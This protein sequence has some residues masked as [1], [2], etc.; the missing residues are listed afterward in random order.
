DIGIEASKG[1]AGPP[2]GRTVVQDQGGFYGHRPPSVKRRDGDVADTGRTARC[3]AS[4]RTPP[5]AAL[6]LLDAPLGWPHYP[7]STPACLT[8]ASLCGA[9]AGIP[10]ARD[11]PQARTSAVLSSA[12]APDPVTGREGSRW[13]RRLPLPWCCHRDGRSGA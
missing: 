4:C 11:S 3:E 13:R 12:C 2:V 8:K 7:P 6:I 5:I 1:H 10:K 9:R